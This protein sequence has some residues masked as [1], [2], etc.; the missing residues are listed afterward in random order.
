MR[1]VRSALRPTA[2]SV[3]CAREM[4]RTV[5]ALPSHASGAESKLPIAAG[6]VVHLVCSRPSALRLAPLVDELERRGVAQA[7][8]DP[9]EP[10]ST[11]PLLDRPVREPVSAAHAAGLVETMVQELEPRCLVVAGESDLSVACALAAS[12][13]G[14]PLARLGAGLRSHDWMSGDDRNRHLLDMLADTLL[15]DDQEAARELSGTTARPDRIRAVGS[16]LADLALSYRERAEAAAPWERLRMARGSY[17]LV[18]LH[19]E[20]TLAAGDRL[21]QGL[22]ALAARLPV[23]VVRPPRTTEVL[24]RS[25]R[26]VTFTDPL[27]YVDFLGMLLGARGVVT[28]SSGVQEET[29]AL[30]IACYTLR[31]RSERLATL[32][33]GTNR[34]VGE[35]PLELAGLEFAAPQEPQR[36]ALWDGKAAARVADAL[37]ARWGKPDGECAI[38]RVVSSI[39]RRS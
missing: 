3:S 6:P 23:V 13:L 5:V 35:D 2:I 19:R 8:L 11:Q 18:A 9:H 17:V 26:G 31:D 1:T 21:A 7:V 24:D 32:L 34:L 33:A 22:E 12:K 39:K 4:P 28:D 38:K 25:L 30:G 29:T 15:V 37:L 16:T 36:P 27:G 14:V 10:D 20:E